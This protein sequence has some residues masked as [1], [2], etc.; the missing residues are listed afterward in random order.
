MHTR[1]SVLPLL[2]VGCFGGGNGVPSGS[3]EGDFWEQWLETNVL[4]GP[5]AVGDT[6]DDGDGLLRSEEEELGTDPALADTDG[7]GYDDGVEVDGNTDPTDE[8]DK[9]YQGGWAIGA[10]RDDLTG[11]GT[12]PGEVA[13]DFGLLD[14]FGDTLRL[15]DFC[16]R[17]VL[18]VA[19]AFW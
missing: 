14:Q 19:A 3:I 7:D 2:L 12:T 1:W 5:G 13:F 11:T 4:T 8:L 9:P 6:D 15:H 17:A 16:D 10:C 18:L